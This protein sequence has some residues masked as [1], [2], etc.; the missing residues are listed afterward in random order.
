MRVFPILRQNCVCP[1][2]GVLIQTLTRP[3]PNPF[4]GGIHIQQFICGGI[5]HPKNFANIFGDL[6]KFL[7]A[8]PKGFLREPALLQTAQGRSGKVNFDQETTGTIP[9]AALRGRDHHTMC[10][11]VLAVFP[12]LPG[13]GGNV[14]GARPLRRPCHD[15][16]LGPVFY[17]HSE[18][19]ASPRTSASQS[20]LA[21]G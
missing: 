16:A 3:T 7:L 18:S 5:H 12:Q 8:F 10:P 20:F 2:H 14:N 13:F 1:G 4:V 9:R 6:A 17:A 15:L 19:T 11:L 21:C